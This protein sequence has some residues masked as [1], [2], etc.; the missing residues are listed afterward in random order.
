MRTVAEVMTLNKTQCLEIYAKN[1]T[2]ERPATHDRH[3]IE[4]IC[5]LAPGPTD[6]NTEANIVIYIKTLV[7]LTYEVR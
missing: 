3:A 1:E 7:I 5:V 6:S 4:L 2:T